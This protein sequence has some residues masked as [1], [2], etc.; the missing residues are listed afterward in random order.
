VNATPNLDLGVIG[1]C[2][3]GAL[4]DRTGRMV[5]CCLP[6]FDGDPVFCQ[7]L[8][9]GGD[10]DSGVF[11]VELLGMSRSEQHYVP[12]TA[13]LVTRLYDDAGNACQITDFAPRFVSRGRTFRPITLV[14]RVAPLAGTPRIRVVMRPR[15]DWGATTPE[16]TKG[17]NHVRYV[18]PETTLRLTTNAPVAYVLGG[19][20]FLLE[21]ALSLVLGP[22]ET[23][24]GG[25]EE[26]AR[27]F[28]EYTEGYWRT[29][30][31]R[32]ALPLEWQDAVVRAAIT[33]KL[34]TFEETGAI[35]AAMTTSIPEAPDTGRNWDYRFCW[36]RDAFFVVRAL[37][38]LA[39]VE[40]ME[41]YL[42]YLNNVISQGPEGP[43]GHLQP[44][45]GIGLE[46]RLTERLIPSL[47]GY[48]GMGP[49]RAG[50][51]AYEHVQ[52]DVYGNV[53]LAASQAFFD[54]RLFS[55]PGTS[56]FQRLEAVG[57]RAFAMHDQP[58]AGMWELRTRAHVHTS[59]SLMCWAAC[60]RLAKIAAH[61]GLDGRAAHWRRRAGTAR[62][63]IEGNAWD[64]G[65][66]TYVSA[67]GGDGMDASLLLMAEVGFHDGNDPRFAS[68]LAAVERGLKRGRHIFRYTAADDFGVPE[69]AFNICT[70]W[71]IDA[72]TRVGRVGEARET[73]EA[74]LEERNTVGLLSEDIDPRTSELWGNYPQT[75]SLVGIINAAMRL[76]AAWESQ[77]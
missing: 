64:P 13:I 35:V 61:L 5:W 55:Q 74:M 25:V 19:T 30:T 69:T 4:V 22:D 47:R 39:E 16:C 20:P 73:F 41:G 21:E 48:R 28:Q 67:F 11:A 15:F 24:Q 27:T 45:F 18:G 9:G 63:T 62:I 42:R 12:N 3:Y 14:R 43:A 6:R 1:N 32:L 40:T 52:H 77:I 44:V 26:T 51:Q 49:V 53:V 66:D 37:N 46:S 23:L 58:D 56:D 59:S 70:F 7:L 76:S 36:L 34:C 29:W 68:T 8:D 75:Y 10:R 33:L 17:S 65:L 31:R 2:S 57:E 50:N 71:Y 60:D 54:R 38:S 72:L